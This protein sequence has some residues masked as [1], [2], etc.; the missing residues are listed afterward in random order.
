[1]PVYLLIN[2]IINQ[3]FPYQKQVDLNTICP[4]VHNQLLKGIQI[5]CVKKGW[6]G[7]ARN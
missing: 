3:F 4:A 7:Q 1:M 2:L 6:Q 5:S